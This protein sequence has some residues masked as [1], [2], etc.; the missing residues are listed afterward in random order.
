MYQIDILKTIAYIRGLGKPLHKD[1]HEAKEWSET[2]LGKREL[3]EGHYLYLGIGHSRAAWFD[4][5]SGSVIKVAEGGHG[6]ME[7]AK[8]LAN[9]AAV[10][11][12][13]LS[14]FFAPAMRLLCNNTLLEMAFCKA[15]DASD[16]IVGVPSLFG[17]YRKNNFG[18]LQI[19]DNIERLV[20]LDY[21]DFRVYGKV[22]FLVPK[23]EKGQLQEYP[24]FDEW[25]A[26][27]VGDCRQ[28]DT[29]ARCDEN[30]KLL[31]VPD[32]HLNAWLKMNG[33]LFKHFAG[34][35][36]LTDGVEYTEKQREKMIARNEKIIT[37]LREISL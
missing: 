9:Y 15:T 21:A 18:W 33:C 17:Y 13:G 35:E 23:I 12:G 19:A 6:R 29:R 30:G 1:L 2:Y 8:E 3:E 22:E 27:L 4:I 25:D 26:Y 14:R 32:K 7:N 16:F 11:G 10:S 24:L 31:P 34:E 5:R 36:N 37:R 20:S 28:I